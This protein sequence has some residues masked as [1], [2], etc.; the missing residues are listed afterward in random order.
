MVPRRG[1]E[2]QQV[3]DTQ[4]KTV[5]PTWKG[6]LTFPVSI[7]GPELVLRAHN[8]LVSSLQSSSGGR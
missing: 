1:P 2:P 3:H 4:P 7:F 6:V 8:H 5:E